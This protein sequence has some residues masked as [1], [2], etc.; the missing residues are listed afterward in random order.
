MSIKAIP[1][2]SPLGNINKKQYL[3]RFNEFYLHNFS[4]RLVTPL[5]NYNYVLIYFI[6]YFI[7][8]FH[9]I[10]KT[11]KLE[12]LRRWYISFVWRFKAHYT[13]IFLLNSWFGNDQQIVVESNLPRLCKVKELD[14]E[15]S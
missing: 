2:S 10:Q 9:Y 1:H 14:S 7:D 6:M 11:W 5:V 13:R 3:T 15:P 8:I 12:H 4:N